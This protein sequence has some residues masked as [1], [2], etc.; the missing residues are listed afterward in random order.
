MSDKLIGQVDITHQEEK[1]RWD[2]LDDIYNALATSIVSVSVKLKEALQTIQLSEIDESPDLVA[3]VRTI[4]SDFNRFTNNVLELRSRHVDKSGVIDNSEDLALCIDI[5]N[6][7]VMLNDNFKA[8]VLL[9][10]LT[11]TEYLATAVKTLNDKESVNV[12]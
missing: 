2:E 4:T 10:M 11:I 5:F 9:P 3:T 8:I 12:E 7:Y 6:E 1:Q